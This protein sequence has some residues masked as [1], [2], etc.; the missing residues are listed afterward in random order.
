MN[1]QG[2]AQPVD[3]NGDGHLDLVFTGLVNGATLPLVLT[4]QSMTERVCSP[5]PSGSILTWGPILGLATSQQLGR[6][7]WRFQQRWYAGLAD[8]A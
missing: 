8:C 7:G 2:D 4:R 6:V 1:V 5:V 3:L